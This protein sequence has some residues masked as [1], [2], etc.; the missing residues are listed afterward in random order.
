[1]TEQA[2]DEFDMCSLEELQERGTITYEF[3]NPDHRI[4]R[5]RIG[6]FWDGEAAY[7]LEAFCPHEGALLTW[8][9]VEKGEVVCPLHMAVFDLKT[10]ECMDKFTFNT[11]AFETE[12]RDGRIWI[13]APGETRSER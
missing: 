11:D 6:L 12:I 13:K 5:H 9:W 10:G 1:M 2:T 8:G 3:V 4:G 7:A